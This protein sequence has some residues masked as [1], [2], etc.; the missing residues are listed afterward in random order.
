MEESLG[1][2]GRGR[3]QESAQARGKGPPAEGTNASSIPGT[4]PRPSLSF[5][6]PLPFGDSARFRLQPN[7]SHTD[8]PCVTFPIG[9]DEVV[10]R[11]G[12]GTLVAR[13]T[14][15]PRIHG[16]KRGSA[17]SLRLVRTTAHRMLPLPSAVRHTRGHQ[18]FLGTHCAGAGTSPRLPQGRTWG[19]WR[20]CHRRRPSRP[21]TWP[22][23]GS[24]FGTSHVHVLATSLASTTRTKYQTKWF[25]TGCVRAGRS[26]NGAEW[27]ALRP[28]F[29]N[30]SPSSN[31]PPPLRPLP[32]FLGA[33][34]PRGPSLQSL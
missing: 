6:P 30:V 16:T 20:P 19:Q 34:S 15:G 8:P 11:G 10:H 9:A 26:V 24:T 23:G 32:R 2:L 25:V 29:K 14:E 31:C 12:Q 18:C 1:T 17:L 3:R 27:S 7:H 33:P 22:T 13:T 21:S 28:A 5:L 4:I